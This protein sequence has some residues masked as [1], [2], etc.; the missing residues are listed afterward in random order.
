MLPAPILTCT[1]FLAFDSDTSLVPCR[2][3]R[4]SGEF[5]KF[6]CRG[7]TQGDGTL[8]CRLLD[9]PQSIG[10]KVAADVRRHLLRCLRRPMCRKVS[11]SLSALSSGPKGSHRLPPVASFRAADSRTSRLQWEFHVPRPN[12]EKSS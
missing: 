1:D 10:S 4:S 6:F 3:E 9:F 5:A 7:H 11:A 8:L 2:T 12:P